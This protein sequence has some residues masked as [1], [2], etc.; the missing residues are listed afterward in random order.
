[1]P[2][3]KVSSYT[4]K[5]LSQIQEAST[6]RI[7]QM[8]VWPRSASWWPLRS[9]PLHP[10]TPCPT[11]AQALLEHRKKSQRGGGKRDGGGC[12]RVKQVRFGKLAFL[13]QNGAFLG[14][15]NL[16]SRPFRAMFSVKK[17]GSTFVRQ[18]VYW[19]VLLH[20]VCFAFFIT[21]FHHK[22]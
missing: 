7:P 2:F 8:R 14:K 3:P 19:H 1:M 13:Q 15:N 10:W 22:N 6:P 21:N 16:D 5:T 9:M 11:P 18:M 17:V 4:V 12:I 20:E